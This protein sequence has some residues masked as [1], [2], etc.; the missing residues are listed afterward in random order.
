M[1]LSAQCRQAWPSD[2]LILQSEKR[3]PSLRLA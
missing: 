1:I 2:G 3:N